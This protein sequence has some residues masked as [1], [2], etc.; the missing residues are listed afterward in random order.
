M[1]REKNQILYGKEIENTMML[2]AAC[3]DV[4]GSVYEFRNIKYILEPNQLIH[5][6]SRF[7]DDTV[8]TC[9]VMDGIRRGLEQLPEN[10]MEC[11]ESEALLL[12]LIRDSMLHFG[13]QHPYAG[14]GGNFIKWLHSENPKPYRSYGN[15]SAMRASYAGWI[16]NTL[17]EAETL[18]EWSAK[19]SH[20]H[21]EGIKGAKAVAGCIFTLRNRGDKEDVRRYAEKYYSL[22]FTLDVIRE[23]YCFDVSC[24]GSVPQAIVAFL[25]G[26][27]FPNVIARA[28]SIGGDSDTIGAIA[29]SIAEAKYPIP[30]ELRKQVVNCLD[31]D[32][33]DSIV[34]GVNFIYQRMSS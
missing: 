25:E 33:K 16:A 27:S 26:D 2:G 11:K 20:N 19:V 3:G 9:A 28:I 30:Q 29:G 12:S 21:P 14:Y 22:D 13:R 32:L 6:N 17:E 4:A 7:T 1:G 24:Q 5:H 8:M 18:G 10:W 23:T 15:G 34:K 31:E